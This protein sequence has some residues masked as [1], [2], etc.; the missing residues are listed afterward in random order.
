MKNRGAFR[1][2]VLRKREQRKHRYD[3]QPGDAE[4]CKRLLE[5]LKQHPGEAAEAGLEITAKGWQS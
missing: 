2:A 4:G 5:Y 1:A 3:K